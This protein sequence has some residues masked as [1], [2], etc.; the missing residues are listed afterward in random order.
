MKYNVEEIFG[1]HLIHGHLSLPQDEFMLG[2]TIN[3]LPGCWTKPT[4]FS[5]VNLKEIHGHIFMLV[6]DDKL[7]A[8]E[9]RDGAPIDISAV[10]SS[11]FLDFIKYLKLHRL[12]KL[13][14]LQS[15][16]GMP[17]INMNEFV[18]GHTGTVMLA[19]EMINKSGVY[20]YT[21][22]SIEEKDG[23]SPFVVRDAHAKTTKG[24]HRVFVSK[25]PEDIEE[26]RNILVNEDILK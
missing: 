24:T 10:N 13:L 11:F 25:N 8:Y 3:D 1:L 9:Y 26:L 22:W 5:D 23:Q 20:R 7:V 17:A 14:G 18:I 12:N 21:G 6:D 15:L 2:R 19:D 4:A 16:N